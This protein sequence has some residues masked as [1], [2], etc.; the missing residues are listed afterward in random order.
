MHVLI[1]AASANMGGAVTYLQNVLRWL[2]DVAPSD[3]FTVYVPA[4]TQE[5]ICNLAGDNVHLAR[6]PGR[7]TGGARRF[8]FDQ[9][10]IPRLIDELQ[11]DVLFS[12]T[13]FGSLR[14]VCPEVL[15]V[16]NPVYF[17]TAFHD[18]YRALGRSLWRTRLRRW[19]SLWCVRRAD[20]VLFPTHAM[21]DMVGAYTDLADKP[22]EAVHYGFDRERFFSAEAPV[23]DIAARMQRWRAEGTKILLSVSTYAVHKNFETL[24]EALPHLRAAGVPVRLVTTTSRDRTSDKA[25]YDA[26]QRRARALG[27]DGDWVETGY[28]AYDQLQHLYREADAYVFPSFTESFGHSLVEAMASGR[29][30]VAADTPVNREVCAPAGAFFDTF[31]SE[32][33]ART[34]VRVLTDETRRQ[35]L[36]EASLERAEHFSWRRYTE[37]LVD[38]F[39]EAACEER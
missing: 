16:R 39:R 14:S 25:E 27:V 29:P 7:N 20:L 15:L 22:I 8:W 30:V 2:P 21:G 11:I 28:V 18:K 37:R 19:Y 26:L 36:T 5:K 33:C 23:P 12:S 3:R 9:V 35:A 34:L 31:D 32:D 13:G 10:E 38:L 17:N 6:F 1:N 24:V 4:A